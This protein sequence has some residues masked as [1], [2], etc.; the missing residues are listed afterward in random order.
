MADLPEYK[1][2]SQTFQE[3]G[4]ITQEP[5]RQA[6]IKSQRVKTFIDKVSELSGA[7]ASE[8]AQEAAIKDA[9]LKPITKKQIEDAR[10][11]GG[12]LVEQYTTGG[13]DYNNAMKKTLGQQISGE[14]DLELQ[15]HQ[16]NV[17]DR[18][19]RGEL[20][21]T[22]EIL[23]E[24]SSPIQGQVEF[25]LNVDPSIANSYGS[26]STMSARSTL[27]KADA[28]IKQRQEDE[29]Y[30]K[31]L[32]TIENSAVKFS[33]YLEQHPNAT[34]AMREEFKR[35]QIQI[36]TDNSLSMSRQQLK[37]VDKI[38]ETL[39]D[40]EDTFVASRL[41]KKY[42]G[43]NIKEVLTALESDESVDAD[44]FRSKSAVDEAKLTSLLKG[45]L[46]NENSDLTAKSLITAQSLKRAETIL[47]KGGELSDQLKAEIE[48]TIRPN[49]AQYAQYQNFLKFEKNLKIYRTKNMTELQD[50]I[51]N[52]NNRIKDGTATNEE[53]DTISLLENYRN[54]LEKG[55]KE[56]QVLTVLSNEKE[57]K[58]LDFSDPRQ[59]ATDFKERTYLMKK[60]SGKYNIGVPNY[61]SK[62]EVAMFN[63]MF[64]KA[65]KDERTELINFVAE[66]TGDDAYKVFN[67]ITKENKEIG[68]FAQ[69]LIRDLS[70]SSRTY[71][72]DG[73]EAMKQGF[74]PYTK[75][76]LNVFAKEFG[77]AYDNHLDMRDN[78]I[79][80]ANVIYV[81]LLQAKNETLSSYDK[82][83]GTNAKFDKDLYEKALEISSGARMDEDGTVYGGVIDY[84]GQK[85]ALPTSIKRDEFEGKMEAATYDDFVQA[86]TIKV[87]KDIY[88]PAF[89]KLDGK[90]YLNTYNPETGVES[91]TDTVIDQPLLESYQDGI[92]QQEFSLNRIKDSVL[93]MES[94]KH[95]YISIDGDYYV[96]DWDPTYKIMLNLETIDRLAAEKVGQFRL[97]KD[98]L[99][100]GTILNQ[101]EID[102]KARK[103]EEQRRK[104]AK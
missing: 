82:E 99:P 102:R 93:E 3:G 18:V 63:Q 39:D 72:E 89:T 50:D 2:S 35:V 5:L 4:S 43:K 87:G 14:L 66:N 60:H 24:L 47:G 94:D 100:A 44:H 17:L 71:Y 33:D 98:T 42:A 91:V 78:I 30:I 65:N 64:L 52:I 59:F 90:Y 13:I 75:E 16:A 15:Q 70:G 79:A 55:L 83:L 21:S 54:G 62:E 8:Y 34:A 92:T 80:G 57:Y 45:F 41:A 76:A 74:T 38:E 95:A 51:T 61:M 9:I 25:L 68:H 85:T 36:A 29:N 1:P 28:I 10:N 96:P 86:M 27:L 12:N 53:L 31:A 73:M 88:I 67:Q 37:L 7:V 20:S 97:G 103:L 77:T 101:D 69:L 40:Q 26:Q 22:E 58:R 56:D 6:M 81:G 84:N 49:T 48:S 23:T 19:T 46:A 11:T 32:K 104:K